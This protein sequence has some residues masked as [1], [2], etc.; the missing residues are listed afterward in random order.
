MLKSQVID[1]APAFTGLSRR[2]AIDRFPV[3]TGTGPSRLVCAITNACA[4]A[5]E[6]S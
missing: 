2:I 1:P 4:A 5:N 3:S 6:R